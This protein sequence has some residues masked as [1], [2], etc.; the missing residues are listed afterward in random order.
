LALTT[1][2]DLDEAA[3]AAKELP[4]AAD[5]THNPEVAS[6]T[7][8]A[9]GIAQRAADPA[10]AY[11]AH[12]RGVEIAH[13][14]GNRQLETFHARNLARVAVFHGEPI[15]ALDYAMLAIRRFYNSGSFSVAASAFSVLAGLLD[16]LGHYEAAATLSASDANAFAHATYPE[17]QGTIAHLREVLGDRAYE[18][19]R[20]AGESMTTPALVAYSFEQIDNARAD[21]ANQE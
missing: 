5:T 11:D 7:L 9:Y 18:S 1:T 19:L 13:G 15:D 2:G 14:S 17:L 3:A 12:R 8:L 21:L 6:Y 16:R 4:A 10:A 20:A